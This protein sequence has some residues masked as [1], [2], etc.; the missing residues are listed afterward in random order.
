MSD[1]TLK[2]RVK[3][4]KTLRAAIDRL[5]AAVSKSDHIKAADHNR[6]VQALW[7]EFRRHHEALA[8]VADEELQASM[9][10]SM[11]V[12][13]KTMRDAA[14]RYA[15]MVGQEPGDDV[16]EDDDVTEVGEEESE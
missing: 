10:A 3:A 1:S 12:V 11:E 2:A 4:E 9:Q 7:L 5:N 14:A 6:R 13:D 16:G 8:A 15:A